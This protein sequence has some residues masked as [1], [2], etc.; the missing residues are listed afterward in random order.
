MPFMLVTVPVKLFA[1]NL[2]AF[3]FLAGVP[4]RAWILWR[5]LLGVLLDA[6]A[7]VSDYYIGVIGK[8]L[9]FQCVSVVG[10][11]V[12]ACGNFHCWIFANQLLSGMV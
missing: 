12:S 6:H 11:N 3:A 9:K 10:R 2:L 1:Q 4:T 5:K 8:F 7:P